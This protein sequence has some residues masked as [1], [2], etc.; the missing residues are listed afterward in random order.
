MVTPSEAT[1]GVLKPWL[2][3]EE[4]DW[5]GGWE[6]CLLQAAARQAHTHRDRHLIVVQDEG[7]V[8]AGELWDRDHGAGGVCLYECVCVHI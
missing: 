8:D 2:L 1:V 7:R 5:L 4:P 3:L 6:I